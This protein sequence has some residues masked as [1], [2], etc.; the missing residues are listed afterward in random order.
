MTATAEPAKPPHSD[1]TSAGD[2]EASIPEQGG[3]AAEPKIGRK[4]QPIRVLTFSSGGV[5]TAMQLGVTHALLVM[6]AEAPDVVLGVSAGA[7]NA[8]ALAEILQAGPPGQ[9]SSDGLEPLEPRVARFRQILEDFQNCPTDLLDAMLPDAYQIDAQKPVKTLRLPVHAELER[10]W[11]D[12]SLAS[13]AGL[14]N[15]YNELLLLRASVGTIT[16]AIR[17]ILGVNAARE[18]LPNVWRAVKA[19]E[20]FRLWMLIGSVLH[21]LA[22]L[23]WPIGRTTVAWRPWTASIRQERGV[24]AARL[25]FRSGLWARTRALLMNGLSL[26]LLTAFWVFWSGVLLVAVAVVVRLVLRGFQGMGLD[27]GPPHSLLVKLGTSLWEWGKNPSMSSSIGRDLIAALSAGFLTALTLAVIYGL[28]VKLKFRGRFLPTVGQGM[29]SMASFILLLAW[30]TLI[31]L[32]LSTPVAYVLGQIPGWV[33]AV[34]PWVGWRAGQVDPL[35]VAGGA[36]LLGSLLVATLYVR[37]RRFLLNLLARYALADSLLHPH[38]LRQFFVRVFD[39]GYYG[40][41]PMDAAVDG[42]LGRSDEPYP[43]PDADTKKYLDDYAK[44]SPPI[45]VAVTVADVSS[46]DLSVVGGGVSTVDGLMAATAAAPFFPPVRSNGRL[47]IDAANVANQ[48]TEALMNYLRFRVHP[49]ATA[50]H[51]YSVASLPL[52]KG[53]LVPDSKPAKKWDGDRASVE[54][55]ELMQVLRRAMQTLNK[56]EPV[57]DSAPAKKADR[58]P[59]SAERTELV[60]VIGRAMQIQRLRDA[61]LDQKLVNVLSRTLTPGNVQVKSGDDGDTFLRAWTYPI[62]PDENLHSAQRFFQ[63]PDAGAR[64]QVVAETVADG[65]RAALQTMLAHQIRATARTAH[66]QVEKGR[67]GVRTIWCAKVIEDH[68]A[69]KNPPEY[70]P[71]PGSAPSLSPG[72]LRTPGLVEVCRHCALYRGDA[73]KL[74]RHLVVSDRKTTPADWYLRDRQTDEHPALS[75]V[76]RQAEED[77]GTLATDP[78]KREASRGWEEARKTG[79][80]SWPHPRANLPGNERPTVSFLFSGGVFRGVYQMGV[81]NALNLVGLR[82]DVIA[83]ASVGSITAAMVARVFR[84]PHESERVARIA[85]LS[86]T[87]LALDRLIL[88]DRFADFVRGFTVRAASTRFSLN[89]LD[90]VFRAFDK[91]VTAEFGRELR[92]VAAGLERLFYISPFELK[93]LLEAVRRR[94]ASKSLGLLADYLQEWLGRM[95]VGNQMLGAEPLSLLIT[96]HVLE[97]LPGYDI[98]RPGTIPFD[99][100]TKD[101]IY[102]LATATNL[103]RGRLEILG[104]PSCERSSDEKP[105]LLDGLLASSAFPGVFRPRWSWEVMPAA[106]TADQYIDGGVTDNLPLDAVAQFLNRAAMADVVSARP[107]NGTVPHLLLCASLEPRLPVLGEAEQHALRFNWPGLWRR[108]SQLGY[109]KKIDLYAK[110]QRSI[111]QAVGGKLKPKPMWNPLDLEVVAIKPEWLCSTFAFH[112]MLNFRRRR[113]AQSIAHGCA[114]TLMQLARPLADDGSKRWK[115]AWGIDEDR[116]PDA[117][118]ASR[119]DPYLPLPVGPDEC[120]FKPGL[121]CPFSRTGTAHAG[122][123]DTTVSEVES[124]YRLCGRPDTHRAPA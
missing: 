95:G 101:G 52:S 55:T 123:P 35:Y 69:A 80:R 108:A 104:D 44:G 110:I 85:R 14:I 38:P 33:N 61:H 4:N 31:L 105:V 113:Q 5:D 40:P 39:P 50:I 75:P 13:R 6:R 92:A 9:P 15:F 67:D 65:C 18:A 118:V 43:E 12:D 45:R 47:Y 70:R 56:E 86:A 51:V 117:Q 48:T 19:M 66:G 11:R 71:F 114:S 30:W 60:H 25:I 94:Q 27:I 42:A 3:A 1:K 23:V 109:N 98:E 112:P 49:E 73:A 96:E 20:L 120:W 77:P 37:R 63:A 93:D 87:Y 79:G 111:R 119:P 8:V 100:F 7:V 82:P 91:P 34:L 107:V 103:T 10:S 116:L 124:I 58:D 29:G 59:E 76:V 22:P 122:L 99:V 32:V 16:R 115:S 64:R 53:E 41:V 36:V 26:L 68:K 102:F 24:T 17:R 97:G 83:G 121:V 74:E 90:R 106:E 88:T 89:Q 28:V 84:E 46:G 81:L 21:R 57:P 2:V 78:S 54:R 62:E 72:E